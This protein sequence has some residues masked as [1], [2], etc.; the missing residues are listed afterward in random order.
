MK[1]ESAALRVCLDR[2][3]ELERKLEGE[4]GRA[5]KWFERAQ[6]ET[7]RV[8]DVREFAR[9]AG[10]GQGSEYQRALADIRD[11]LWRGQV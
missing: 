7:S 6:E 11:I 5:E 1:T 10:Q 3:G 2:I 4:T 9:S 8:D